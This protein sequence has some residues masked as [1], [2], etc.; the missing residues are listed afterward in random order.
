MTLESNLRTWNFKKCYFS[1]KQLLFKFLNSFL[2]RIFFYTL[3]E[4][5]YN[6]KN[7]LLTVLLLKYCKTFKINNHHFSLF[8]I[9]RRTSLT[10]N[11]QKK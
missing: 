1:L 2:I 4:N 11:K 9:K 7:D 6:E 8:S 5:L 3:R 10:L